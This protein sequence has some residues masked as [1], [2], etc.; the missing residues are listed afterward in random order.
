MLDMYKKANAGH[1]GS[2]LSCIDLMVYILLDKMKEEDLFL[3][4]KG[5]A[6]GGLYC[7]LNE[8]GLISDEELN[9]FYKEGTLLAGHPPS[10]GIDGIVFAT[11]SLGHGPSLCSG[12]AL[13][14]KFKNSNSKVFCIISDGECNEGSV[15]EAVMF[16]GHNK[17][18][19]LFII[20]DKNNIQAFGETKNVINMD[21]MAEKWKSF[22]WDVEECDGHD[23]SSIKNAVNKLESKNSN[24]PKCIIANTI[25]GKGVSFM[26]NTVE[27]HYLPMNQE[28]YTIACKNIKEAQI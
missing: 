7:V 26:E 14:A 4:S 25:K 11:G 6:A 21:N 5:H 1:I 15:W 20:I 9:T 28:Q 19:N 12:L 18:D 8:K 24:S 2:S 10:S 17:L 27:W 13:G 3:L 22:Y 16:A 23:F